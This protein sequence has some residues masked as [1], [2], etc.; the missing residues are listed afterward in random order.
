M[1]DKSIFKADLS[2][3]VNEINNADNE[4]LIRL[5]LAS[6]G[7]R[8]ELASKNVE[9]VLEVAKKEIESLTYQAQERSI[10]CDGDGFNQEVDDEIKRCGRLKRGIETLNRLILEK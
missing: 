9:A 1:I 8:Q 7:F 5:L 6:Y 4:S 3:F 10:R 2:A